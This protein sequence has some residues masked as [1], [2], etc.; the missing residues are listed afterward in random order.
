LI[1][2]A[3]ATPMAANSVFCRRTPDFNRNEHVFAKMYARLVKTTR[4]T[5]TRPADKIGV[6]DCSTPRGMRPY[7]KN[8][9]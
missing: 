9:E 2:P 6:G 7:F 1:T 4:E 8:G 3:R 5:L